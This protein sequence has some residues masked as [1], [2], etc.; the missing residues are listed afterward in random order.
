MR[1]STSHVLS[2]FL[3]VVSPSSFAGQTGHKWAVVRTTVRSFV[4]PPLRSCTV[5]AWRWEGRDWAVVV[6]DLT[7]SVVL[8]LS[9]SRRPR[10]GARRV[11]LDGC[12][13]ERPRPPPRCTPVAVWPPPLLPSSP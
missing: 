7:A 1:S 3:S 6:R 2:Q 13:L 5:L 10:R 8:Q 11:L 9:I 4:H 12:Y